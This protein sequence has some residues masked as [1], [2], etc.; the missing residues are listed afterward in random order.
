MGSKLLTSS[1]LKTIKFELKGL[2][3]YLKKIQDMGGNI[4]EAVEK[5]VVESAKPIY[6]D[7]QT[8]QRNINLQARL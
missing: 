8:G 1:N 5:A 6:E 7:I 3:E 2:D 4:D